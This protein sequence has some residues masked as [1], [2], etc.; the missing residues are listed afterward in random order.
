VNLLKP[1][2]NTDFVIVALR[3]AKE[4]L[5]SVSLFEAVGVEGLGLS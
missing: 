5:P 2:M 1:Q 3:S 4:A